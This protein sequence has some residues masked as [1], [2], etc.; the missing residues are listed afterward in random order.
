MARALEL[1]PRG[2]GR[3][4]PNPLVGAVIARDDE[5]L[6]EGFHAALG[7]LHAE[8]AA[9]ADC[10]D[11]GNDP[12]GATMYVTLEP[13]AHEG[14]QPPCVPAIVEAGITQVVYASDDP[15]AHASGRGVDQLRA[16]GVE[17]RHAPAEACVEARS[18][19]QAFFKRA[20]TGKPLVVF[21]A[22]LTL[23]GRTATAAGDSKWISGEA[24]RK[25]VHVWRG[26]IDAICVGIETVLADDPLLT[27]RGVDAPRQ[28][29]RIVFD[30]D[31]R[32]PT[33][34]QLV[35]SIGDAP[36][37]VI[38]GPEPPADRVAGLEALGVEVAA[39]PG[40]GAER[41][42]AALDE[43]GGRGMNS[44]LLE[45]GATLAGSFLD[46]GEVDELRL[47]IAPLILGGEASRPLAG[48][49]GAVSVAEAIRPVKV[50]WEPVGEDMLVRAR[51]KDW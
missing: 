26:N 15:S 3:V 32:L 29:T 16:A 13:C 39:C 6:G 19:N 1:A 24:S 49:L 18:L 40:D 47:F 23:D 14:R 37:L 20:A 34:S 46:A 45:G 25:L 11:R 12:A 21:K 35:R 33:D 27:A 51:M 50:T 10:E 9:I 2:T 17:T 31:V 42:R 8:R 5:I 44:M 43:V 48:G 36:V 38:A 22:A 28:P 4:S 30:S 7:E 41:V